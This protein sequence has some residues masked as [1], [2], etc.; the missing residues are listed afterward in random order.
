MKTKKQQELS[1]KCGKVS[2]SFEDLKSICKEKS[3]NLKNQIDIPHQSTVTVAFWTEDFPELICV[4][5]FK[6]NEKEEIVYDLDF[7]ETTL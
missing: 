6:K 7:S 4:G 3:E 1:V 2:D 5:H